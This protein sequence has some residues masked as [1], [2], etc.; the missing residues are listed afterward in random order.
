MEQDLTQAASRQRAAVRR[1]VWVLTVTAVVFY[2]G[3]IWL[4]GR[5]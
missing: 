3:F 4:A 1:T 2:L 5:P